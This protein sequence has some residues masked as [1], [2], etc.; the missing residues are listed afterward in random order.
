MLVN[1][2]G[3][4]SSGKTSSAALL[5]SE[6][7]DLGFP[8]EFITEFARIYIAKKRFNDSN[9]Q[10]VLTDF[11]QS[12][13]FRNQFE[14]ENIML[15]SSNDP[16]ILTDSS[17]WNSVLYMTP[18]FREQFKQTDLCKEAIDRQNKINP[19]TFLSYP[20]GFSSNDPNRVHSKEQSEKIHESIKDV[21]KDFIDI[22]S[23][24]PLIGVL[25]RRHQNII[26]S[27]YERIL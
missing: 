2:I 5:F 10:V 6:L 24:F 26:A 12:E 25:Q 17:V 8:C 16:L 20:V 19:L 23:F 21:L 18:D 4:P 15:G 11:D 1:Y 7:K 14:L 13:I 9:T 22:D 27:V 3:S